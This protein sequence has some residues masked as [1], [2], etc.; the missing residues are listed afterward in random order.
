MS[1]SYFQPPI[2][3]FGTGFISTI[4]SRFPLRGIVR[5]LAREGEKEQTK[6]GEFCK[7]SLSLQ[8]SQQRIWFFLLKILIGR[9]GALAPSYLCSCHEP[10]TGALENCHLEWDVMVA[11]E[12]HFCSAF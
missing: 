4:D 2:E 1:P 10:S 11:S 6:R 8:D 3:L 5:N 7:E 12:S 9:E